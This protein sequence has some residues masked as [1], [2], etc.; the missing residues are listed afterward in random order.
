MSSLPFK[1]FRLNTSLMFVDPDDNVSKTGNIS[2]YLVAYFTQSEV[3]PGD[4]VSNTSII[5]AILI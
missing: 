1:L 2:V 5:S 3:H 4:I